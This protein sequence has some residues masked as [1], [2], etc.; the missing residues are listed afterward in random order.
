MVHRSHRGSRS[1]S[2]DGI[3]RDDR[4]SSAWEGWHRHRGVTGLGETLHAGRRGTHPRSLSGN[5]GAMQSGGS[6]ASGSVRSLDV[7]IRFTIGFTP[8]ANQA[9][10]IADR[11]CQGGREALSCCTENPC[12]RR[13]VSAI[14]LGK[15]IDRA[16]GRTLPTL[17]NARTDP[18]APDVGEPCRFAQLPC[19]RIRVG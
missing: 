18:R 17:A 11:S 9:R 7:A 5:P 13:V 19:E 4:W 14:R 10:S 1:F 16:P 2:R 3:D 8:E 6:P 12:R 15:E